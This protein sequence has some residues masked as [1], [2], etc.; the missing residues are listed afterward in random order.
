MSIIDT[1]FNTKS[2]ISCLS[3]QGVQT[4][5]RYYN[6]SNSQSFPEKRLELAEAQTL[7]SHG[8]RIAV[9]FQQRQNQIADFSESKGLAAGR[10]AYRHA[11]DNIGQPAGSGI[12][13]SVDFDASASEI[14]NNVAPYFKGIK[15]AFA[16]ESGGRS[17]YRTG[18]YGSGLVCTT[19]T[20]KGLLDLSWLAM[21]RGFR[22]TQEALNA[23][24]FHLAQRAPAATL[25]GLGV[26]FNDSNPDRPDFGAFTVDDDVPVNVPVATVGEK[27]KV[28][29]RNGLRLR[30]G[31]GANF[32]I[33]GGLR[34]GQIVFVVSVADGWARVDLEGDG[35]I[36]GF[37]SVGFLERV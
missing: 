34:S 17:E 28:V 20:E 30:E 33:I 6:F 29:A 35:H 15:A 10:R 32:D 7:A 14:V 22:G 16:E 27:H 3:S 31:P 19:L 8:M 37:A 24:E 2:K 1:P 23:G 11:H 18:A 9:V 25:C 4:V 12:Y 26:D 21:S 5:I 13:F 36:D